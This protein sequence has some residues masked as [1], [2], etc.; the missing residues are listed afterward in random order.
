MRV[1]GQSIGSREAPHQVRPSAQVAKLGWRALRA[2]LDIQEQ[3]DQVL[4]YKEVRDMREDRRAAHVCGCRQCQGAYRQTLAFY[5]RLGL[6]P[7]PNEDVSTFGFTRY[8][9]RGGTRR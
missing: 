2:N 3:A 7:R 9:R 1:T 6:R 4:A 5:A 8:T